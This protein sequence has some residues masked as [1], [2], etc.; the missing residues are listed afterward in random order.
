MKHKPMRT[1]PPF[2]LKEIIDD[3]TGE[4]GIKT[5]VHG[6]EVLENKINNIMCPTT[7]EQL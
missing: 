6:I 4:V 2:L 1:F 5:L 3:N 7:G